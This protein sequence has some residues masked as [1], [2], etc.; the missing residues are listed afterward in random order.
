[1]KFLRVD[2]TTTN[3][4]YVCNYLIYRFVFFIYTRVT[5]INTWGSCATVAVNIYRWCF[6]SLFVCLRRLLF[7]PLQ[8]AFEIS[9]QNAHMRVLLNVIPSRPCDR[10]SHCNIQ[11]QI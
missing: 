9:P 5:R 4:K 2:E 3:H 11:K 1:L 7:R 10:V 6:K 8:R